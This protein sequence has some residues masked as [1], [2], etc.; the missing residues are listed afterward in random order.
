[1]QEAIRQTFS[2]FRYRGALRRGAREV[3][4]VT[5]MAVT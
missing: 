5:N 4:R 2:A 1:M 3:Q